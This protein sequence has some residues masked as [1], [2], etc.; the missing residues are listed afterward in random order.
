MA[1]ISKT[2]LVAGSSSKEVI[3]SL[4]TLQKATV[5]ERLGRPPSDIKLGWRAVYVAGEGKFGRLQ[6]AS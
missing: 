5:V 6:V 3:S 1:T 2:L 4:E